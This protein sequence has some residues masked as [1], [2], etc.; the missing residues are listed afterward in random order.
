MINCTF[1]FLGTTSK[2]FYP[3]LRNY[4]SILLV[5]SS[6]IV[7]F[8]YYTVMIFFCFFLLQMWTMAS[9]LW[10]EETNFKSSIVEGT[11]ATFLAFCQNIWFRSNL[12][13]LNLL[14]KMFRRLRNC[15][16]NKNLRWK[17]VLS[18]WT[19]QLVSYKLLK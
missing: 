4:F 9:W 12:V 5:Y 10:D 11:R 13:H 17:C 6:T 3:E 1:K 8:K 14:Y 7:L 2:S 15:L 19:S 16:K 18:W